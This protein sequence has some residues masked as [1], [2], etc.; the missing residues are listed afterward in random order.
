[1]AVP[2]PVTTPTPST[3]GPMM[4]P[5]LAALAT[6]ATSRAQ[7]APHTE[8]A[9]TATRIASNLRRRRLPE[10]TTRIPLTIRYSAPP[11]SKNANRAHG[12]PG[13]LAGSV[14]LTHPKAASP[15]TASLARDTHGAQE[16]LRGGTCA[17][18]CALYCCVWAVAP[19]GANAMATPVR[20]RRR[21]I[22]GRPEP[23]RRGS[24]RGTRREQKREGATHDGQEL[25]D[26]RT[27]LRRAPGGLR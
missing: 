7:S 24:V 4:T 27:L 1:M 22:T 13:P 9:T 11:T 6:V 26:Q 12:G 16:G 18:C 19:I 2:R 5:G 17:A 8:P 10:T 3:A 20:K 14:A 21:D 25:A 15:M 23:R